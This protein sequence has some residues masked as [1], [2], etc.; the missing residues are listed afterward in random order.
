MVLLPWGYTETRPEN[1]DDI[2]A[3]GMAGAEA[4]M[5]VHGTT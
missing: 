3:L 2:Y 5:S 4:L 1:Y